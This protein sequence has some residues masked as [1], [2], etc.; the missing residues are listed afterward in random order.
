MQEQELCAQYRLLPAH[1]LKMKEALMLESVKVGQVRRAD[2]YQ[3]FKVDPVKTDRVYEL[4]VSRGWIQGDGPNN[5]PA[6][7]R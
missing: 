5:A 7:D 6:S 2:A 3:M 1:Y 4:L